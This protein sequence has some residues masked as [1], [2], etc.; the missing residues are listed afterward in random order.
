MS[1]NGKVP[2][3]ALNMCNS[4]AF[5]QGKDDGRAWFSALTGENIALR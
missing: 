4:Q 5:H 3:H 1:H 2:E